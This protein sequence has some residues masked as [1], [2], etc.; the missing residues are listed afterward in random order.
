MITKKYWCSWGQSG[1]PILCGKWIKVAFLGHKARIHKNIKVC[2]QTVY[3]VWDDFKPHNQIPGEILILLDTHNL[4]VRQK[5]S[6]SDIAIFAI[7]H[8][9][10]PFLASLDLVI[11]DVQRSC[12]C[13]KVSEFYQES[14]SEV[15]NHLRQCL[16]SEIKLS[17]FCEFLPC[18]PRRQL[19]SIY[20]T[21]LGPL[22]DSSC[23]NN[24]FLSYWQGEIA[25]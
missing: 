25:M 24:S 14:D 16:R 18:D 4:S 9:Q 11:F 15:D 19:Q 1:A 22:T 17:C 6:K 5:L 8:C 20:R 21:K 13:L 12:G 10:L 23:L 7:C 2:F 3:I